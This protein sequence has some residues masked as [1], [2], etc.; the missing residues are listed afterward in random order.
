MRSPL[1]IKA[2]VALVAIWAVFATISHFASQKK[3]TA[4][5]F[6]SLY[7]ESSLVDSEVRDTP[8]RAEDLGELAETFNRMDFD[9]RQ[10]LRELGNE[11]DFFNSLST[12][13]QELWLSLT[14]E[15]SFRK[16]MEALDAMPE[17]QRQAFI[18]NAIAEWEK[19]QDSGDLAALQEID[20]QVIDK[21]VE[22]GLSAYY[23]HASSETKLALAPLME[24]TNETVQG[25]RGQ[26]MGG[27]N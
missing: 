23:Q 10:D 24:I 20:P 19:A 1:I 15:K 26:P 6:V 27:F 5:R 4:Q 2:A 22:E 8:E 3:P 16:L 14:I 13:E 17:Q 9:A 21:I 11:E 12:R 7:Q 25:I 18:D